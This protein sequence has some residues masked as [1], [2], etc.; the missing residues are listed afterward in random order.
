MKL[1]DLEPLLGQLYSEGNYDAESAIMRFGH[2]DCHDLTLALNEKY[3]AKMIALVGEKSGTPVHSCVVVDPKTT[4]DAYGINS[5][6]R[7]IERYSKLS[8]AN[9]GE[10]V[11]AK[12]ITNREINDYV[13]ILE[14]DPDSIIAEFQ[15]VLD[16][17]DVNINSLF[18][19]DK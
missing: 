18:L 3:G 9:L 7:T 16:L 4:L 19:G 15:P 12:P 14:E 2:G 10:S 17:L 5:I 6:E 8:I 13:G 1:K 11:I